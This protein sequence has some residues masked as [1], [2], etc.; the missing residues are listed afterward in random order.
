MP[1]ALF[2]LSDKTGAARFARALHEQGWT[3][4]STG[5]TA[6][7]L[8]DEGVPVTEVSEVTGHPEMMEGRVKTLHPAIHAG[9]LFRRDDER[10]MRELEDAG[11]APIDLLAV[12]LYPFR[13]TIARSGTGDAEAIEMIDIGGPAMLRAAAKNHAAVWAVVDPADYDAVLGALADEEGGRALRRRLAARAFAHTSAYDDAIA[14]Y[15]DRGGEASAADG[16]EDGLPRR[17]EVS[18]RLVEALRYGENPQQRGGW[19][20][21][22]GEQLKERVRQRQ[23]KALSYNNLL[24]LDAALLAV[25]GWPEGE[26]VCA[27]VKHGT[28]C[29][30]ATAATAEEAYR[31]AL[32]TDPESAFGSIV[33]F[34]GPLSAG[35]AGAIAEHFVEVVA[36]PGLE[37]GA[38]AALAGKKN[39]R[40][41]EIDPGLL[42][43]RD[44]E[45]RRIFAGFL[46]QD[47][48]LHGAAGD[49]W[50]V[51][52]D[53][54]PTTEEAEDLA[55]AWRAVAA[56]KSNAILIAR[57]GQALGIGG[58][59]TSRVEA[60][61]QAISRARQRG[62]DLEGAVLASDAFFPFPDG[63]EEAARA[64]VRAVVQPGGSVRDA[65]VIAAANEH[66]VAMTMTGRRLF[67]H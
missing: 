41:L 11:Y 14:D 49:E 18:L 29:G 8:R 48:L 36:A 50:S 58:G 61:R 32:E 45:V 35:A 57:G 56:V 47:S 63:L 65:E 21:G 25:S 62:F 34:S 3:I 54:A 13:E 37:D 1:R 9:L 51:A 7:A 46:A 15:L 16:E 26:A 64:G 23:G 38:A 42:S 60:V 33:A 43:G 40:L 66:D 30:I 22:E 5:G 39:L 55:F 27:I 52:T 6:A 12:N 17:L 2:S 67:R 53:R 28:P 59:Q 44:L 24:D 31:R 4:L 20:A 10:H 19:Y